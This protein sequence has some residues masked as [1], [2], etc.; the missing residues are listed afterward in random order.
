MLGPLAAALAFLCAASPAAAPGLCSRADRPPLHPQRSERQRSGPPDP[1]RRRNRLPR[2][3]VI[4]LDDE[5]TIGGAEDVLRHPGLLQIVV[6]DVEIAP[7]AVD[8]VETD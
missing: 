6:D 3:Q 1:R 2:Q 5:L 8:E 4:Q 7:R